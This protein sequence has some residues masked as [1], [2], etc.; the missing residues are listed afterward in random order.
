M[1]NPMVTGG[2]IGKMEEDRLKALE[3]EIE[4]DFNGNVVTPSPTFFIGCGGMGKL[5]INM[6][7][8][9]LFLAFGLDPANPN[10]TLSFYKF[11]AVDSALVDIEASA[12]Y[13]REDEYLRISWHTKTKLDDILRN[14]SLRTALSMPERMDDDER[15][16]RVMDE[17]QD[18]LDGCSQVRLV[19]RTCLFMENAI[20]N[21]ASSL[22]KG[23]N[24][25]YK[26]Y[27]SED[28]PNYKLAWDV[29]NNCFNWRRREKNKLNF[30]II[31]SL[32][33]GTGT[34]I[35]MDVAAVIRGILAE[36]HTR[37]H[38]KY[39]R[40]AKTFGLFVLPY[41]METKSNTGKLRANSY[42]ALK[43]LDYFM[44]GHLFDVDY[45]GFDE[46]LG[47]IT[48][49]HQAVENRLF[50]G[51]YLFE[52][53]TASSMAIK[54][55]HALPSGVDKRFR[56]GDELSEFL[57]HSFVFDSCSSYWTLFPNKT[58]GDD[59]FSAI[60]ASSRPAEF[61][62]L[63]SSFGISTLVYPFNTLFK[64]IENRWMEKVARHLL[65]DLEIKENALRDVLAVLRDGNSSGNSLP[66]GLL[67]IME[68]YQFGHLT[69]DSLAAI[70]QEI[71]KREHGIRTA[72]QGII[73]RLY[74]MITSGYGLT[75]SPD[76]AL[77]M[78]CDKKLSRDREEQL[79]SLLNELK[80]LKTDF[81][82]AQ[83]SFDPA[84]NYDEWKA[85]HKNCIERHRQ[86]RQQQ[87]EPKKRRFALLSPQQP[88]LRNVFKE[89]HIDYE[90]L[91]RINQYL[92]SV[93][94]YDCYKHL[95]EASGKII[96][97]M[98]KMITQAKDLQE[99]RFN[100]LDRLIQRLSLE[101]DK[102][103]FE[104][105]RYEDLTVKELRSRR[106]YNLMS[107]AHELESLAN[108]LKKAVQ[109]NF[110][111]RIDLRRYVT[112]KVREF[113]VRKNGIEN[114]DEAEL[115]REIKNQMED[116]LNAFKFKEFLY[117]QS[118]GDPHSLLAKVSHNLIQF[119]TDMDHYSEP[120]I[121]INSR[122]NWFPEPYTVTSI[123]G[124]H[125]N[126]I[127]KIN[128]M[129]GFSAHA[130]ESLSDW[131]K[132]YTGMRE[133][134]IMHVFAKAEEAFPELAY[135]DRSIKN[136]DAAKL[137][138]IMI[139]SG[140][141][142][143]VDNKIVIRSL[144]KKTKKFFNSI[145]RVRTTSDD[146]TQLLA[147]ESHNKTFL[148]N[149]YLDFMWYR[150]GPDFGW[151]RDVPWIGS[152]YGQGVFARKYKRISDKA[153][154]LGIKVS[155]KSASFEEVV[156][157]FKKHQFVSEVNN[158]LVFYSN[159]YLQSEYVKCEI[160]VDNEQLA[161]EL[162]S[163]KWFLEELVLGF[164]EYLKPEST[165]LDG[166]LD[167]LKGYLNAE[168]TTLPEIFRLEIEKKLCNCKDARQG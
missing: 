32:G 121:K 70:E 60:D 94:Q 46:Q 35:F 62:T 49:D 133:K 116:Y 83:S 144:P 34:G 44:R 45:S 29:H 76:Q 138:D 27:E 15:V 123:S 64:Q 118:L 16:N 157:I 79:Q 135:V 152:L 56:V 148:L 10:H 140:Y 127:T 73:G 38:L 142:Q 72:T 8:K 71:K 96:I 150:S 1:K 161:R 53:E 126:K 43:E 37:E 80:K 95:G 39:G 19:G 91:G 122:A 151:L 6:L 17:L 102:I 48:L 164:C 128:I 3:V 61:K 25:L 158:D 110:D 141:L 33:G 58:A 130:I 68:K 50:Q 109:E 125:K 93:L 11:L 100:V 41:C 87:A 120:Y 88:T 101:A 4:L 75:I 112:P 23:L 103:A 106:K 84:S 78:P 129:G 147:H 77:L 13:L 5:V 143:M 12:W 81:E 40:N 167:D 9:T 65:P 119:E 99:K 26:T 156:S 86:L 154:D 63:Y 115:Y 2:K 137:V 14:G 162:R 30:V 55:D 92:K 149:N 18:S 85:F 59:T 131:R 166:F 113:I 139:K 89:I 136:M 69:S 159:I 47:R 124:G 74:D 117:S 21:L 42:A 90:D 107:S 36:S 108:E 132:E 82:T 22:R 105:D 111:Q 7:K 155:E 114:C 20:Q 98:D 104:Y 52:G 146:F 24:D 160:I 31:S 54:H 134:H 67:S 51:M 57:L 153:E 168:R 97:S 163:N 145:V 66:N 165:N 28:M